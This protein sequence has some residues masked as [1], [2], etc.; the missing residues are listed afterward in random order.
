MTDGGR[1]S[2]RW[3]AAAFV[4]IVGTAIMGGVVF[5]LGWIPRT[6]MRISTVST[7]PTS[8]LGRRFGFWDSSLHA[9]DAAPLI[10]HGLGSW[11]IVTPG[12][13]A[14]Y[15]HNI[16]LEI[17]VEL[18]MAGFVLLVIVGV[19]G[20]VSALWTMHGGAHSV[21]WLMLGL[22]AFMFANALISGDINDNRYLFAYLGLLVAPA[23]GVR[24]S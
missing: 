21:G 2:L 3:A 6:F 20:L 11:P 13:I 10:G 24:G 9:I 7:A 23:L 8:S 18:G 5:V 19:F 15:P 16:V 12:T 1:T 17:L 14:S 4:G 22:T